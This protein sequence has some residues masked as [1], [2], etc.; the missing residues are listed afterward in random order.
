VA[1]SRA[2]HA[3]VTFKNFFPSISTILPIETLG[4]GGGL[5]IASV[6][7]TVGAASES[8]E[9]VEFRDGLQ[10]RRSGLERNRRAPERDQ[11]PQDFPEAQ[12]GMDCD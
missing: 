10:L 11:A 9:P 6:W 7:G 4:V 8:Q 5:M 1:D 2:A 3:D 12:F